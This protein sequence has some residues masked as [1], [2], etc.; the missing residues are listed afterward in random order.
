MGARALLSSLKAVTE[1]S[2]R[3][4]SNSRS[5]RSPVGGGT[6]TGPKYAR[7]PSSAMIGLPASVPTRCC[8]SS[9][10]VRTAASH[11]SSSAAAASSAGNSASATPVRIHLVVVHL[12]LFV[13]VAA[14]NRV[15]APH[16][17]RAACLLSR[18]EHPQSPPGLTHPLPVLLRHVT[19]LVQDGQAH[20]PPLDGDAAA[21]GDVDEPA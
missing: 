19:T 2:R 12:P 3:S 11:F 17:A 5:A 7:P 14:H 15:Q 4:A 20:Q 21:A 8:A 10:L 16:R 18:G 13:L 6:T 1:D 9:W